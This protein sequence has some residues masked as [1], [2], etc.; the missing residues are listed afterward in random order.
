MSFSEEIVLSGLCAT[1]LGA[2]GLTL[3]RR[4][5]KL[6]L[7]LAQALRCTSTTLA[8]VLLAPGVPLSP[9]SR[10]RIIGDPLAPLVGDP[11]SLEKARRVFAPAPDE[12]LPVVPL[13][14]WA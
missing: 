3:H 4:N 5:A 8:D 6:A 7:A 2:A 14:S 9:L 12:V 1:A 11:H 13:S 10:Y